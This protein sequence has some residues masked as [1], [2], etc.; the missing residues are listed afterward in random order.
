M[1]H[2]KLKLLCDTTVLY[3]RLKN[4]GIRKPIYLWAFHELIIFFQ[5]DQGVI[6]DSDLESWWPNISESTRYQILRILVFYKIIKIEKNSHDKRE[7]YVF[8]LVKYQDT[9]YPVNN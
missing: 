6:R 1:D 8:I 9:L 4:L 5:R 3:P 7:R 2:R